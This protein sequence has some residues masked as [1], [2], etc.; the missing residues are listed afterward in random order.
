M[1][2][3]EKDPEMTKEQVDLASVISQ[4]QLKEIDTYIISISSNYWHKIAKIVASTMNDLPSRVKGIPDIFYA[5]RIRKLVEEG[6]LEAQGNIK[7]MRNCE[8]RLRNT[9]K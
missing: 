5:Q 3:F 9:K 1:N 8:V 4:D 2:D 6:V 7:S